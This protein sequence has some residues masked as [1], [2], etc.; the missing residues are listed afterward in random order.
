[1]VAF[2]FFSILFNIFSYPFKPRKAENF[3]AKLHS[4]FYA[5]HFLNSFS[6]LDLLLIVSSWPGFMYFHDI[7]I[8]KKI[9]IRRENLRH[10]PSLCHYAGSQPTSVWLDWGG[11]WLTYTLI[12]LG[13][14][15]PFWALL[16]YGFWEE[17]ENNIIMH[18]ESKN[19]VSEKVLFL[20][21]VNPEK[22]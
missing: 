3:A 14:G 16:S 9:T 13:L 22:K 19:S 12:F 20:S 4:I 5:S 18:S 17:Q 7:Y 1:M 2:H 10:K 15:I 8:F 6:C 11:L 21:V